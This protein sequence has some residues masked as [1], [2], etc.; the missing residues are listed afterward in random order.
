MSYLKP[1]DVVGARTI[2][3]TDTNEGGTVAFAL[4][5][6]RPGCYYVVWALAGAVMPEGFGEKFFSNYTTASHEFS[7]LT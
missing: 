4:T 7:Q 6:E 3:A 2:I 1:G 5:T